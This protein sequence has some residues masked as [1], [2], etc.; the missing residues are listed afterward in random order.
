MYY[1]CE[2]QIYSSNL[3]KASIIICFYNEDL[4]TL[5]RSVYSVF[6]RTPESILHEVIL[7][8]D[9]SDR[10][11]ELGEP[12][13]TGLRDIF[14]DHQNNFLKEWYK[15]VRILRLHNR[16]GLIRARVLGARNATGDVSP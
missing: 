13:E 5:L 16:E 1:R 2:K 12:L 6:Q 14:E 11:D 8:D 3:P 15:K 7:V 10:C 9:Y 4:T